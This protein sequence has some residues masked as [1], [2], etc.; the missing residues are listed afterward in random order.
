MV[1]NV[2][3]CYEG[4]TSRTKRIAL[5]LSQSERYQ[6]LR[7]AGPLQTLPHLTV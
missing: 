6:R 2:T 3:I 7:P 4:H 5:R 1:V